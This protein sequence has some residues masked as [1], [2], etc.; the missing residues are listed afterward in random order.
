M[1]DSKKTEI[2]TL[3]LTD[4]LKVLIDLWR[5]DIQCE[6]IPCCGCDDCHCEPYCQSHEDV[7]AYL[8]GK[9]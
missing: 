2:H 1:N 5:D 3:V 4:R 7:L 6:D 8:T 9:D